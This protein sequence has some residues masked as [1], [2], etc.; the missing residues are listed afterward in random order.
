MTTVFGD[1]E[2]FAAE[3][4][5]NPEPG[6]Q[7]LFG[8]VCFW[9]GGEM[10][11][12][13]SLGTSLRDVI[14][15]LY[16]DSWRLGNRFSHRFQGCSSEAVFAAIDAGLRSTQNSAVS[17]LAESEGWGRHKFLPVVDVFD[18][19]SA[20]LIENASVARVLFRTQARS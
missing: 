14:V 4:E 10:I 13:Y 11:G 1:K 20:Y 8:K 7:W 15:C 3:Y 12:D 5:L 16:D 18:G 9:C 19:S 6:E 17:Q 2:R